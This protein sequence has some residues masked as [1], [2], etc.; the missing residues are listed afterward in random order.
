MEDIA[1]SFELMLPVLRPIEP[2]TSAATY[3]AVALKESWVIPRIC[4]RGS[5]PAVND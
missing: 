3:D 5:P 1:I 2:R 4:T